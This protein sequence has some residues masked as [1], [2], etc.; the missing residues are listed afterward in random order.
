MPT[1]INGGPLRIFFL[2]ALAMTAFAANS[3]LCR[4]AL[5]GGLIDAASFTAIRM[6]S[7]ILVPGLMAIV[8]N[9]PVRPLKGRTVWMPV[10][11]AAYA[12]FFS[13]AYIRLGAGTGALILFGAVQATMI[14]AGR[15]AGE[16]LSVLQTAGLAMALSG[17]V[18]LVFPGLHAPS[19][20]YAGMMA[21]A[22][23]A[24]GV[25]SLLGKRESDPVSATADNFILALPL[26]LAAGF[27]IGKPVQI[28]RASCR[29]R[30]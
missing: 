3:I 30:V 13:F 5:D 20:L 12:L 7:G 24:W 23:A 4:F 2:T 6:G 8:R 22:G 28:G 25:Y 15:M 26:V 19:P 1:P 18:C 21:M 17:L 10:M 27:L 11:L 14:L 9:G 16:R 29:E